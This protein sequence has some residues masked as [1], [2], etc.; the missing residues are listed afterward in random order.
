LAIS[1]KRKEKRSP[2]PQ[3]ESYLFR[4]EQIAPNYSFGTNQGSF[5]VGAYSDYHHTE[6]D[7]VCL[8]PKRFNGR[9]T[10]FT[11]LADRR[12]ASELAETT[13]PARAPMGI[14]TLTMRGNQSSYLGSIPFDAALPIPGLVLSGGYRFI[15][16]AGE[17]VRNGT[18]RIQFISFYHEYDVDA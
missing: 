17:P 14:G 8:S 15:Y 7:S 2:V 10:R 16:L 18:A 5:E 13:T 3:S 6:I 1:A 4:I 11:L 12:L 9:Q